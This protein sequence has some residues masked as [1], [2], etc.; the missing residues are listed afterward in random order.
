M[1]SLWAA[2]TSRGAHLPALPPLSSLVGEFARPAVPS[3]LGGFGRLALRQ[4]GHADGILQAC[5]GSVAPLDLN[6]KPA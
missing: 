6:V 1:S 2:D 4:P 5:A 3:A